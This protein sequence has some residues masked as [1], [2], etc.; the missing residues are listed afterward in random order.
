MAREQIS[1]TQV[2]DLFQEAMSEEPDINMLK[3]FKLDFSGNRDFHKVFFSVRCGCGT[4]ALLSV[5]VAGS[6][7][8]SETKQALPG[9]MQHLKGKALQFRNM[10]CDMH[11]RMRTGEPSKPTSSS[12][13]N[14]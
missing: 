14:P 4:A 12:A 11:Q 6:K 3:G 9:L 2:H 8:L 10:T 1:L 7:S 13:G 5:E